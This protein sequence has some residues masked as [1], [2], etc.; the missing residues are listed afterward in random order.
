MKKVIWAVV[1]IVLVYFIVSS[2]AT[3]NPSDTKKEV[4]ETGLIKIGVMVP[5]T[6]DGA[7]YGEPA[8]N[9]YQIAA[10]EINKSGG[11]DGR[12]IELVIE[13][14]KC[15]G[16]GGANAAQKLVNANGVK[17]IIGGICS[18]ATLAAIPVIESAKVALFSPGAS[19]PD[20][21]AKS[22][23]FFRNY[24][25]DSGQGE[26]IAQTLH[27]KGVKNVAFIQEQTDY[28]LGVYKS[29][30]SKFDSFGGKVIKEEFPSTTKDFR[31]I[32]TKLKAKNPDFLFIDTQT[33]SS[34]ELILKQFKD[35]KWNVKIVLNDVPL[36]TPELVAKYA[37]VLD[38]G[39]GAIF[40]IDLTNTKFTSIV[41]AYK[42]K[43]GADMPYQ[44]YGQTEYDSVYMVK[45]AILAVGYDG[46][47]I[48]K[49]GHQVKNWQGASG[50][51]T[52]GTDGDRAGAFKAQVIKSGKIENL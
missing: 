6:G 16:E 14:D 3:K 31:S 39:I 13:D 27:N 30:N 22:A 32:L 5:L 34:A 10:D 37:S 36:T 24:P 33:P 49:W 42:T 44:N 52:I 28:A 35:L 1:A 9:I 11:V 7:I 51:V 17:V 23:Y 46:E 45:D 43:Y 18:G 26:T 20:L 40:G 8:R 12:Q 38:G 21:T 4:K 41:S 25:S 50:S 2:V 19:S 48:A 47:K 29:F 15:N